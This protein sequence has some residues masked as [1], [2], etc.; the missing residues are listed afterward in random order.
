MA[1][2]NRDAG[3]AWELECIN[4]LKELQLYPYATSTRNES[5][6]RDATEVDIINKN[7]GEQGR[8]ADDFQCKNTASL[9]VAVPLLLRM[10]KAQKT[11]QRR[12]KSVLIKYTQR[13]PAKDGG[14]GNMM[15]IA[16]RCHCCFC[17]ITCICR[18]VRKR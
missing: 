7:E 4:L 15:P 3:N 1:N 5:R 13:V 11:G 8:M 17:R 2:R 9:S 10:E 16:E 12:R 18:G 6:S 14:K